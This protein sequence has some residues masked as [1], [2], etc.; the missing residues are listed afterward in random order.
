MLRYAVRRAFWAIP[1]LFGI[2]LVVFLL[3]TLLPDPTSALSPT[4]KLVPAARLVLDDGRRTRFLDLPRFINTEPEDVRSRAEEC[5]VHIVSEDDLLDVSA[6][7]LAR[8]G[9]AALPYVLPKFDALPPSGRGR[10][11]MALLPVAARMGS[12]VSDIKDPDQ[13]AL[14]WQRFWEDRSVDFTGPSAKRA[15]ERFVHKSSE[16]RGRELEAL[17]TFV[18]NDVIGELGRTHDHDILV[19]LSRVASRATGRDGIIADDVDSDVASAI[20]LEWQSW[21]YVFETDYSALDGIARIAGTFRETRYGKWM[22]GAAT[23]QLGL[24]VRDGRPVYQK[25]M[26]RAPI[27]LTMT[28]LA[29]L[30][31]FACAIPIGA[32]SAW[33]RGGTLD[34]VILVVLFALYSVPTFLLAEGFHYLLH[35]SGSRD[36][37]IGLPV[38]ALTLGSLATLSRHQRASVLEVVSQDYIRAAHA[39]GLSAWRVEVVH[40]L[41]NAMM[42]TVTLAALQFPTLLGG[43]FVVE[44][45]FGIRGMGWETLRAF[46]AHDAVWPVAAVLLAATV[47]TILLVLSDIAYSLL[48]PRVR[49]SQARGTSV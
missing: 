34:S 8:M 1:T 11:A 36:Y 5:V 21:W 28:M 17:D 24:S 45:V 20:V 49:E 9:G 40:V 33:K 14:F 32:L 23:G 43:A 39:K 16:A 42:P 38:V 4:L 44:E 41:R 47:T 35:A 46:E 10:V 2:S 30:A 7:R 19:R 48:D 37:G 13:A 29:L 22:L 26:S 31:S 3:T 6:A 15:V 18:L 12:N 25:L 27:T